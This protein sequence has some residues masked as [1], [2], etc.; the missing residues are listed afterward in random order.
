MIYGKEMTKPIRWLLLVGFFLLAFARP[1]YAY[2]EP[3]SGSM[4]LQ[5]LLGGFA[6]IAVLLQLFWQRIL[7]VLGIRATQREQDKSR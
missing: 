3:G 2:L 6:G 1:A 5:V 4:L 7:S